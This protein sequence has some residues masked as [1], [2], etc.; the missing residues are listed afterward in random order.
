M[1]LTSG[2]GGSSSNK[3]SSSSSFAEQ[4]SSRNMK[5]KEM[6]DELR[7]LKVPF[8]DCITARS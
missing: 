1:D 6:K 2:E 5:V 4:V 7:R 3:K 8:S